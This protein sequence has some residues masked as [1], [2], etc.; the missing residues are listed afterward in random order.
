MPAMHL[1]YRA[2]MAENEAAREGSGDPGREN[3]EKW[4]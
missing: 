3:L 4:R 1:A 2:N